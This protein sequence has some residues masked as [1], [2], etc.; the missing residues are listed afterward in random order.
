MEEGKTEAV[1]FQVNLLIVAK[2]ICDSHT[3]EYFSS[4]EVVDTGFFLL[5]DIL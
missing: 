1:I 4:K 2:L 3:D 5:W